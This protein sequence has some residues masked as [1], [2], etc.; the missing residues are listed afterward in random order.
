[1]SAFAINPIGDL[2]APKR[3]FAAREQLVF[4]FGSGQAEE[5]H[6]VKGKLNGFVDEAVLVGTLLAVLV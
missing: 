3:F 2:T 1:M 4:E 5:I 6:K